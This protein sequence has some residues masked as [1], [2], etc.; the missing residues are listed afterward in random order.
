MNE[1]RHGL[2]DFILL[3]TVIYSFLKA[4]KVIKLKQYILSK[5]T[6]QKEVNKTKK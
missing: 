4:I 5:L 2:I 3:Y 1:T 6:N